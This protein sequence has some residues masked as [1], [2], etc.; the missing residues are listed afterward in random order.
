MIQVKL[1]INQEELVTEIEVAKLQSSPLGYIVHQASEMEDYHDV[2][3]YFPQLDRI[4]LY[5]AVMDSVED[6][7][8]SLSSYTFC[9][10]TESIHHVIDLTDCVPER[11]RL[12][13]F[14]IIQGK[15][16]DD[17]LH[18]IEEFELD[19]LY[20]LNQLVWNYLR[21]VEP[22]D[23][24]PLMTPWCVLKKDDIR[25]MFKHDKK[26]AVYRCL[27]WTEDYWRSMLF[28][29][30][31]DIPPPDSLLSIST[32]FPVYE[33]KQYHIWVGSRNT[34]PKDLKDHVV[35]GGYVTS[36][37]LGTKTMDIDY[38]RVC[39]DLNEARPLTH[40]ITM[41]EELEDDVNATYVVTKNS[42]SVFPTTDTIST[43]MELEDNIT[44]EEP[45]HTS[46]PRQIIRKNYRTI[47]EI[48]L[49]FDIDSVRCAYKEGLF[50]LTR[51]FIWAA[52][53]KTNYINPEFYSY[54][55]NKRLTKYCYRRFDIVPGVE[56]RLLII[57]RK[58][59]YRKRS[60]SC[61]GLLSMIRDYE[62]KGTQDPYNWEDDYGHWDGSEKW[63]KYD[64]DL[65]LR[66]PAGDDL[67]L[68]IVSKARLVDLKNVINT[69]V[70]IWA[71][72]RL[73]VAGPAILAIDELDY[74]NYTI[75]GETMK[76]LS[77][78]D[79]YYCVYMG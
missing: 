10:V 21:S 17:G 79:D 16:A 62:D 54:A 39:D 51:T 74:Y 59:E 11:L 78:P 44:R 32:S 12:P 60:L 5:D 19:D 7:P 35:A 46:M 2:N 26:I 6:K 75:L 1:T 27:K 50:Y 20:I 61:L 8:Y 34:A 9:S 57:N 24:S 42:Y 49:D 76:R 25:S 65:L 23:S 70:P 33:T 36:M 30:V 66:I 31:K 41:L 71:S 77:F 53:N 58:E 40:Y 73:R 4:V 67:N 72:E 3:R 56:G 52:L 48:L 45:I 63:K 22:S 64:N 18:D 37:L 68:I 43:I 15:Y 38:F 55:F 28:V 29:N 47:A 14:N 13:F 69:S